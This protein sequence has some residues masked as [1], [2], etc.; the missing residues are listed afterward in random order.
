MTPRFTMDQ[1]Q[2]R[3]AHMQRWLPEYQR[4]A[5]RTAILRGNA[6]A[7]RADAGATG[8]RYCPA[9]NGTGD[10]PPP[11]PNHYLEAADRC[12]R[13]NGLGVV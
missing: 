6:A 2:E 9:C 11:S 4:Q 8:E 7:A 10:A 1:A 3:I 5:R 13:C 12:D